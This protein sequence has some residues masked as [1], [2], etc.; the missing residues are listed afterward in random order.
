MLTSSAAISTAATATTAA[1]YHFGQPRK[2]VQQSATELTTVS[3]PVSTA[4]AA[5]AEA[6][7]ATGPGV[8]GSFVDA[9]D[10]SIEPAASQMIG[11]H[12]TKQASGIHLLLV[13]HFLNRIVGLGFVGKPDETETATA[14]RIA[15]SDNDLWMTRA[16]ALVV[17]RSYQTDSDDLAGTDSFLNGS[18]FLESL[19]ESL[20]GGVPRQPAILSSSL[21]SQSERRWRGDKLTR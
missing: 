5:A 8:V 1:A 19:T 17:S 10:T 21:E 4:A 15:V 16:N 14:V 13:V 3:S 6:S 9:N 20:V 11:V 2:C 12:N 7:L 18:V